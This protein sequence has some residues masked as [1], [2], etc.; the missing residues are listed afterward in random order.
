MV[1]GHVFRG[2]IMRLGGV[3]L[4][5]AV[6][7]LEIVW[8]DKLKNIQTAEK[9]IQTAAGQMVD[10][11]FFPEMSFTGFSMNILKTKENCYETLEIMKKFALKYNIFIG[12]GWVNDCGVKAENHYSI[13]DN[14][15]NS[16][17][18]YI[19]IHPFN[20]SSEGEYFCAGNT[21][22]ICEINGVRT[23]AFICYDLRFP[24]IFQYVS[25]KV[26]LIVIPANWPES[27][28]D[29]WRTL[30]KARAIENQV[31][32]AGV[33]CVGWQQDTYYA[34]NSTVITPK[35]GRLIECNNT[36]GIFVV[37]I[38]KEEVYNTRKNFP[39][40]KDRRLDLYSGYYI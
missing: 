25:S 33:N 22:P 11:I 39:I 12:F 8:E 21:I 18:D 23:A 28:Y 40:K 27:R 37:N 19:K 15:G 1:V 30:L 35:G 16:I 5:I 3:K 36:E 13:I 34:G 14:G 2:M 6:C 17:L 32:I 26:E 38:N 10:V 4:K 31:F 20:Y 7:Q 24:E 29:H 9:Y